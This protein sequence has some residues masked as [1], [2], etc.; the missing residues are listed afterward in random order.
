MP[1]G[2][3]VDSRILCK[4]FCGDKVKGHTTSTP[5]KPAIIQPFAGLSNTHP[6]T[7]VL[8][9]T[10]VECLPVKFDRF[11]CHIPPLMQNFVWTL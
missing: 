6:N 10:A 8:E 9:C 7:R 1:V 5:A 4:S 2:S 11:A 3:W